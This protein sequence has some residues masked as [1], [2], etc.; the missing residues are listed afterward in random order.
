MRDDMLGVCKFANL[1]NN[2]MATV[3]SD[4]TGLKITGDDLTK[5]TMRTYLRG[6]VN[7]RNQG[8]DASDYVMPEWV[9]WQYPNIQ[10]PYFNTPEFFSELKGK[11]IAKFNEMAAAEGLA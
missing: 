1:D 4:S 7:E 11:V 10:L 2:T 9:H 5:M 8:Y 6:W 3:I